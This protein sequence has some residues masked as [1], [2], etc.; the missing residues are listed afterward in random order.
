V[1]GRDRMRCSVGG[2]LSIVNGV[3]AQN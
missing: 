2:H 1:S 3:R